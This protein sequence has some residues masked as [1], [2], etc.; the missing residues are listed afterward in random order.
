MN[1]QAPS[2]YKGF[3]LE[4]GDRILFFLKVGL[5]ALVFL[6]YGVGAT[7]LLTGAA[8]AAMAYEWFRMTTGGRDFDEPLVGIVLAA[9]A[10]PPFFS[11]AVGAGGGAA[12]AFLAAGFL[13]IMGPKEN[14]LLVRTALGLVVIGVA[15]ACFVWLRDHSEHGLALSI[16]LIFVVAATEIGSGIYDRHIAPQGDSTPSEDARELPWGLI[17]GAG[18]GVAAGFVAA[19]FYR[20][21]NLLWVI[22]ASLLI[23]CVVMMAAT[24]TDRIRHAVGGAPE[25]SL[26]LGRG[27]VIENFDGLVWASIVAGILMMIVGPLYTW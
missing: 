10:L 14:G 18:S 5:V 25:G 15:G 13:L 7:A 12:I 9:G 19:A 20:E 6:S 4:T 16:W 21:G 27:A 3:N 1:A 24:V 17:F 11:F 2:A 8:C 23:A 26:L 22:L